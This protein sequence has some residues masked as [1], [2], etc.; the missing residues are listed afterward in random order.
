M[1]ESYILIYKTQ[2]NSNYSATLKA[3]MTDNGELVFRYQYI[4]YHD[5][6]D[7]DDIRAIIKSDDTK[8]L[9][10]ILGSSVAGLADTICTQFIITESASTPTEVEKVFRRILAK[11]K[12]YKI[13]YRLHYL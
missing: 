11:I 3:M 6:W 7:N 10:N 2:E 9:A 8:V 1:I 5:S 13:Q 12:E 4:D